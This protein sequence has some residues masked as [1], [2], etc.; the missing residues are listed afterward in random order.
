MSSKNNFILEGNAMII[1]GE[2]LNGSIPSVAKAIA[3]KDADLIRERAG[4]SP[5]SG[6]LKLCNASP[7]IFLCAAFMQPVDSFLLPYILFIFLF[8]MH[9]LT[10][11][12]SYPIA[13]EFG[14]NM[15]QSGACRLRE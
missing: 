9:S 4:S 13:T 5:H 6:I 3:E 12:L 11:R 1:I 2:K 7:Q 8:C 14:Q 15:P 10:Y